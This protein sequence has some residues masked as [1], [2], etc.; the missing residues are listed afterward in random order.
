MTCNKCQREIPRVASI[1]RGSFGT[2]CGPCFFAMEKPRDEHAAC[3]GKQMQLTHEADVLRACIR[4]LL[5]C[6]DGRLNS[7]QRWIAY[8]G[9][10]FLAGRANGGWDS[11]AA[12]KALRQWSNA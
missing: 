11:D 9:A 5:D 1:D 3:A 12:G 6:F 2:F 10:R 7:E 4:S 8:H